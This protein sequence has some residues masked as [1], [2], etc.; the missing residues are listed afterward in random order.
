MTGVDTVRSGFGLSEDANCVVNSRV[1]FRT[2]PVV[3]TI[4]ASS[5]VVLACHSE[6]SNQSTAQEASASPAGSASA[7]PQDK[8]AQALASAIATDKTP[9]SASGATNDM[10]PPADGVL[11]AA[12]ADSQLPSRSPPKFTMGAAG[13]EP[14]VAL[15]HVP[16]SAP[17]KATLQVAVDLGG[18]QGLP[19]V[20]FK[21]E[22]RAGAAKPDAKNIQPVTARISGVDISVPNVPDD[23]KKQLRQLVGSKVSYRVSEDGGSF[24]FTAELGKS[25]GQEL[26]DLL[27]MVVQGLVAANISMPS[28]PVGTGAYWMV[29]SRRNSLGLDWMIYDMVKVAA[30]SDKSATLEINSRRYVVGRDIELPSGTQGPK[31]AVREASASET[32]Q[33]TAMAQ[34]SLLQRYERSQSAKLLLDASDNSGQRM[35][36]TGGQLKFQLGR[37]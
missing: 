7:K 31:L 34:G 1:M 19:P 30:V 5:A 12:K 3:L 32:S 25:K 11:D 16:L 36:Q 22:L 4:V 13:S 20:E 10:G 37:P 8:L 24:D 28:D 23:F 21:L 9:N 17:T 33:A 26:G 27:E 2:K 29:T 15:K 14:R 35:M 6:S 18:G